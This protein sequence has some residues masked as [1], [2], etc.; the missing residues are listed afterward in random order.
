MIATREAASVFWSWLATLH[1][2]IAATAGTR[3]QGQQGYN[4]L[5]VNFN[6]KKIYV[7]NVSKAGGHALK[8]DGHFLR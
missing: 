3:Q 7:F 1:R 6:I 5:L 4:C 2:T 8:A